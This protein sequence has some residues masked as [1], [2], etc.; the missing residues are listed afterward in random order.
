[1]TELI[2]F[3]SDSSKDVHWKSF[4]SAAEVGEFLT[5]LEAT[6]RDSREG[7]HAAWMTLADVDPDTPVSVVSQPRP[8]Y[9]GGLALRNRIGRVW[10][11]YVVTAE[12]RAD[13]ATFFPLLSDDSLFTESAI[14]ALVRGRYRPAMLH[15]QSVPLRVF[16]VIEFRTR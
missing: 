16:Q 10:M 12:G 5:A 3:A 15:G 13:Q 14:R 4:A 2:L 7:A 9:P 1:M 11:S 8:A 6:A